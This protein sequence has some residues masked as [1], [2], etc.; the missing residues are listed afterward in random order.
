MYFETE[1]IKGIWI[2]IKYISNNGQ[3]F[4]N[5]VENNRLRKKII[6]IIDFSGEEARVTGLKEN[7]KLIVK[8]AASIKEGY[9][10]QIVK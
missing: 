9:K 5:L 3:D 1:A 10:V 6:Q 7:D 8:G 4:V 2:P